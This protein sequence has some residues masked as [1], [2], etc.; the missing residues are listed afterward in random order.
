M[1]RLLALLLTLA[2][3]CSS[4][5][6]EAVETLPSLEGQLSVE[7]IQALNGGKANILTQDGRVTFVDGACAAEPIRNGEDADKVVSAMITL[8][9]GDERTHF[10]PWRQVSDPSG[11]VYYIYQQ[12]YNSM[13]VL[14]G[15][16]KVIT[17]A[18]GN[19]LGLTG[20]VV[21]DLPDEEEAE[22]LTAGEAEAKV[23][24]HAVSANQAEPVII[25]GMTQKIVL[26][27]DLVLDINA[28]EIYSQFV[29]A[30]YT[31]NPSG[32]VASGTD[33]PYLAHYVTMAGEYLYSMPT[34]LPGDI[35]AKAGYDASYVFQF[36]EPAEYTGYVDWSDG[37]EH[38]ISITLMRDTRTGMYYLG[39]IEHKIVVADCWE[40][41]YND[42]TVVI[43]YSPDNLEWDQVGLMSLY[44][45]C[46]AFD[47][48]KEIGWISGDGQ[49]TPVIVLKD[50]CDEDHV[51]INNA[52]YAG[53]FYGWQV[54]LSS[55]INDYCQCLD[56]AA[57]EFTHCVTGSLMTYNAY[58]NDYG[59][60]NEGM[61]DI[62][63][64][65]CEML[66]GETDDTTWELGEHSK[67]PVRSMSDP[68]RYHQPAY[69]W[70][71][72]YHAPVRIS[73]DVND[74]GGVHTNSS[75]L[76]NTAYRLCAD[77]GMS[78]EEARAYWFSVDCAMVPGSDYPQ[79]KVL[80]PWVMKITGM[81]RYQ[82]ALAEAIA[83][84]RLG[85]SELP[86]TLREDEALLVLNL[87]DTE[88]FNNGNWIMSV[89]SLNVDRFLETLMGLT[90]KIEKGDTDDLPKMVR[91]AVAPTP[92]PEPK[93][94][95]GF[96][97]GLWDDVKDT[98]KK[99]FEDEP[100]PEISPEQQT[101]ELKELVEWLKTTLRDVGYS[102]NATAGENGYTIQMMGRPGRAVP[103]LMYVEVEPNSDQMKQVNF[104][105]F[106][107]H[108]WVDVTSLLST[109]LNSGIGDTDILDNLLNSQ[110]FDDLKELFFSTK[111]L[112]EW[113]NAL[114]LDVK[115]GQTYEIP[116]DGLETVDL[117]YNLASLYKSA[118]EDITMTEEKKS[119]PKLVTEE[120][121]IQE[122]VVNYGAYGDEADARN[123]VLLKQ[124]KE[125]SPNTAAKWESILTLWKTLNGGLA[126]N[127]GVL[128]D[129]LPD[130][131]ALCLVALG[132]QL[133]PDGSMKEELIERLRVVLASAEKY[134][135]AYVV[136]TGGGTASEN[137]KATEA[138][139][140]AEWLIEN[141]LD[142]K[143]II[144][145]DKSLTTAQNA[146]Y[147]FDILT[148][149]YPQV[150]Q[151]AIISSGYH[152][153]TGTLLFA[154]EATLRAEKA[155][156]EKTA[157]VS[158][159]AYE[160][161]S[162]TLSPM[163]QAGAL[164]ELSGDVDTAFEIYYE[165]YDIHELPPIK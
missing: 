75:L 136:C 151:L 10:E 62:L 120:E 14:G 99:L 40:F 51:P 163:F 89:T 124:L 18:D 159:A 54:F 52:A 122:M 126:V 88:I 119:R 149:K 61:S 108:H 46:K 152:I 80:L 92:T 3:L 109:V 132:F 146:I 111:G 71:L 8:L 5:L 31:T 29:W 13:L 145:E 16:V 32:S 22:G 135:K 58:L 160:A 165:T 97:K 42:G 28:D 91:D 141:G 106:L 162:G 164:I 86:E 130:T 138:G 70:D 81:D 37:T 41:L 123:K 27:V 131:D 38:E 30:V 77:G 17:G 60:I 24:E 117:T 112:E 1:K 26:P 158:N 153:A 144:V 147:T 94:D 155:G 76:N 115:G 19:M 67:S 6:A 161:P 143:R 39:N 82:D 116:A 103:F 15:A 104:V 110:L 50:F 73:T 101:A 121:L 95:K 114:T 44:N 74:H 64:N 69:S 142:K 87:P 93:E 156:E 25:A 150:N 2:L 100:K 7:D 134:P 63:G 20:S 72:Y 129:G 68:Y 79:L 127:P 23:I 102:S 118:Q 113:V 35:A 49:E 133:E 47:Y 34:I 65:V 9:G 11:N 78:L 21:S 137:E 139:K 45:Y 125:L 36:M 140:M 96:L 55:A 107:N 148:E 66:L 33:L 56:V 98:A 43:E 53:K 57:H 128:P 154:A 48:Y 83:A 90:D 84:T 157:V 105:L 85:D 4:A 59:A 12:T